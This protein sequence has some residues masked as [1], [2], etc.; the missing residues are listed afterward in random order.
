[1]KHR[2]QIMKQRHQLTALQL[3]K[4][5]QDVFQAWMGTLIFVNLLRQRF[6]AQVWHGVPPVI[7]FEHNR[8]MCSWDVSFFSD[9]FKSGQYL[10][11][12]KIQS[13]LG[14]RSNINVSV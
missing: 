1:M 3:A 7:Y 14:N 6:F 2:G 11:D 13:A 4:T 5:V 8:P 9:I 12:M 10:I